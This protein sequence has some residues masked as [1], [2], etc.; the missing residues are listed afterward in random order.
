MPSVEIYSKELCHKTGT[1]EYVC[2]FTL[3]SLDIITVMI[4]ENRFKLSNFMNL[5]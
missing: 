3:V 2:Y 5:L 1:I 4:E